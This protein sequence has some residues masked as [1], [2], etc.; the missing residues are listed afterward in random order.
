[1]FRAENFVLFIVTLQPEMQQ[2]FPDFEYQWPP[3]V[4][5]A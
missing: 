1:L 5:E 2:Q 4:N 3:R